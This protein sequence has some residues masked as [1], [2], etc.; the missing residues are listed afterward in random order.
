MRDTV[1]FK[2]WTSLILKSARAPS[3]SS[4]FSNSARA[5]SS[6]SLPSSITTY[7][8]SK[9]EGRQV[10]MDCCVIT[11]VKFSLNREKKSLF[12]RVNNIIYLWYSNSLIRVISSFLKSYFCRM[13]AVF[14]DPKLHCWIVKATSHAWQ[15][16]ERSPNPGLR[17]SFRAGPSTVWYR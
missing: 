17:R 13:L 11:M 15:C 9:P 2:L 1:L 16:M 8:N 12:G 3:C 7:L 6:S 10:L 4:L 5:P 14:N